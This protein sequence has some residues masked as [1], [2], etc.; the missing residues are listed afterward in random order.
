MKAKI[1]KELQFNPLGF[2]P[3]LSKSAQCYIYCRQ[4]YSLNEVFNL[5]EI[6]VLFGKESVNKFIEIG[7]EERILKKHLASYKFERFTDSM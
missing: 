5:N 3:L 2:C 6:K 7:L 1:K 4:T